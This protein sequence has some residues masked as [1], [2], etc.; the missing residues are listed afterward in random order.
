MNEIIEIS[1]WPEFLKSFTEKNAGRP[2]RLGLFKKKDSVVDDYW[3]EDGLPLVGIDIDESQAGPG[4]EILLGSYTHS[5]D[6]AVELKVA[7]EPGSAEEGIDI[8]AS[9]GVTT[10]L[11]FETLQAA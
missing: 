8:V 5:I 6:D 11:R 1:E 3:L 9:N 10:V 4:L 2:T 7:G